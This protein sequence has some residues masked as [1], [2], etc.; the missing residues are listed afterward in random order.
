MQAPGRGHSRSGAWSGPRLPQHPEPNERGGRRR[1]RRHSTPLAR[2]FSSRRRLRQ[3]QQP[4][5]RQR[6]PQAPAP[7]PPVVTL[8]RRPQ[9]HRGM[10]TPCPRWIWR[11]ARHGHGRLGRSPRPSPCLSSTPRMW[12]GGLQARVSTFRT[13]FRTPRSGG[14]SLREV[15]L[16]RRT[17]WWKWSPAR[18]S[19]ACCV[20][21]ATLSQCRDRSSEADR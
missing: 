20:T 9:T 16:C 11:H 4:R 1:R 2:Q 19:V 21:A 15:R 8:G 14:S 5:P 17:S 12:W 7:Q 18:G 10:S 13:S 3:P 6:R